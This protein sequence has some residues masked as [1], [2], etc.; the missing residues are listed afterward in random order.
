VI[1]EWKLEEKAPPKPPTP[2]P[3]PP[4]PEPQPP[5]PKKPPKV[6]LVR[7]PEMP[8]MHR[9]PPAPVRGDFVALRPPE[10]APLG[11]PAVD[12]NA[13]PITVAEVSGQGKE[14]D[15]VGPVD[16][17]DHRAPTGHTDPAPPTPKPAE[18]EASPPSDGPME[19]SEVD[20]RPSLR[21]GDEVQRALQRLYPT[22]L[23]E[24]GVTG[25]TV[26]QFVIGENGRVEPGSVEVLSSANEEFADA[27]RR[28]AS[29]L[30][31]SPAK[32]NGH[33]VRVTTTL[34]VTWTISR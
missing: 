33:N 21:N 15:I 8:R 11:I 3:P 17:T 18:V 25:Q 7:E 6:E 16:S 34:P 27:A 10:R 30:R 1:A 19:V 32:S 2:P 22:S 28:I 4:P 5:E 29:T 14:G 9:Q 23:R 31:F 20:V 13:K 12:P 24:A 26:L